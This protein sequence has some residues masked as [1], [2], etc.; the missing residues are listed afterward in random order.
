MS[1]SS[2]VNRLQTEL[3]KES[4]TRQLQQDVNSKLQSE[5]DDLLKRLAEA[6]NH[7]DQLRLGNPINVNRQF[8]ITHEHH[9]SGD[10]GARGGFAPGH[11]PVRPHHPVSSTTTANACIGTS[12]EDTEVQDIEGEETLVSLDERQPQDSTPDHSS[13]HYYTL[14]VHSDQSR[15]T[16]HEP[17]PDPASSAHPLAEDTS[18]LST[19]G[20]ETCISQMSV[21]TIADRGSAESIQYAHLLKIKS[22][23][24]KIAKLKSKLNDRGS[25]FDEVLRGLREVEQEHGQLSEDISE[26]QTQLEGLK[27]KYRGRASKRITHSQQAIEKEVKLCAAPVGYKYSVVSA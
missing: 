20:D 5:Y 8:V 21:N 14:D 24:G 4:H 6:E 22:L 17:T 13:A 19:E 7:I 27:E 26:S 23:Q 9:Y 2:L 25:S 15:I 1:N 12:W 3:H 16:S 18:S 11:G 10:P